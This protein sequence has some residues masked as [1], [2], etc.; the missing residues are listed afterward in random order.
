MFARKVVLW[1]AVLVVSAL[2]LFVIS[3]LDADVFAAPAPPIDGRP[4]VP[5]TL[6]FYRESLSLGPDGNATVEVTAVPA[7]GGL[8][9]LL[10]PF[11]F[12]G[13]TDFRI[14]SGP[15]RFGVEPAADGA[16]TR[17]VLGRPMLPL[18]W[19]G[20]LQPGDTV[21][22]AA[23]VPG[24]FDRKGARRPYGEF[25]L[26]RRFVNDSDYVLREFELLTIL[27]DGM[28]V[29]SIT[30]VQP[31][32]DPKKTPEPPFAIGRVGE[33][34]WARLH[35]GDLAPTDAVR[36]DVNFRPARRGRLPLIVGALLAILY[37]VFFRDVL[38]PEKE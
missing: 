2:T 14:L 20:D 25:A 19:S 21:R 31:P 10:L 28:L 29:H 27:P 32:H 33:R 22:V 4:A 5:D 37:L 24:W 3:L 30:N 26:S 15:V 36:L 18:A 35:R 17:Q 34:G 23:S 12:E 9:D 13:G 16:R 8:G 6:L 1:L 11:A 7:E 38:R